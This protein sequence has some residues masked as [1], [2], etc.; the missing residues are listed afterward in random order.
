LSKPDE[1]HIKRE[2]AIEV[3]LSGPDR[4]LQA[5]QKLSHA[6][7]FIYS[8]TDFVFGEGGPHC[9]DDPK[10]PLYFF[11]TTKLMAE[12][13]VMES[14]LPYTIIRPIFIYGSSIN[15]VRKDFLHTILQQVQKGQPVN[16]VNDQLRTPTYINDLCLAVHTIIQENI[17]GIFHIS[18]SN[19]LTPYQMVL[20][21][22]E[23]LKMPN[24]LVTPV[25]G[26]NFKEPVMRTKKGRLNI[27]KAQR[28]FQFEP[29]DFSKTLKLIFIGTE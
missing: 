5:A 2:Y 9:E 20:K 23:F 26:E 18:G 10:N 11:G 4:L 3:N 29:T 25:T 7:H 8:S 19:Y 22:L 14:G 15:D 28:L 12:Q 13:I 27:Q 21:M 1:C 24:T 16:I 6:V 17:T